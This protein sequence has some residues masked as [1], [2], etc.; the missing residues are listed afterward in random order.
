MRLLVTG[1]ARLGLYR[2]SGDSLMG[3]YFSYQMFP[4]GL[5][6]AVGDFSQVLLDET[7]LGDGEALLRAAGKVSLEKAKKGLAQLLTFGGFPEPFLKES[8]RFHRRW[9]QEYLTLLFREDLRD[10][11]RI[12]DIRG[13]EQLIELL[14]G[15]VGSPLSMNSLRED[16]GCHHQTVI[17]WLE[18]LKELYLVFTLRPWHL[19][20]LRAIKKESKLYFLDWSIPPVSGFRFENLLAVSL[21][22]LAAR[23]TETGLG[24]FEIR[25][26]RDKEKREVDFLLIKD[27][28]PLALFEAKDSAWEISPAGRYFSRKLGVPF[29]QIVGQGT[30]NEM[31][32]E[33]CFLLPA[34]RFLMLCG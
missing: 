14:P 25:Y 27:N 23:F 10:L 15:K 34:A 3:R 9:Q 6:E 11:S 13:L 33:N 7:L 8:V 20:I 18:A 22:R 19:N 28:R 1:S 16:I 12:A 17:H 4:L 30:K 31:F 21:V 24:S 2:K 32:P 29:Y 26:V 5:P